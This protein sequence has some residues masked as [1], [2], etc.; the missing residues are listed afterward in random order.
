MASALAKQ[1][2]DHLVSIEAIRAGSQATVEELK[3]CI[4]AYEERDA[5][6]CPEGFEKNRGH[7]PHFPIVVNGF[8]MQA[9][10]VKYI[11]QGCVMGTAGG[12]NDAI[13]IQDLYAT[14]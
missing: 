1:Q 6:E 4:H 14:S 9:R 5:V 12:P 8:T 3:H 7:I 11:D 10:Y 2:A 13:F